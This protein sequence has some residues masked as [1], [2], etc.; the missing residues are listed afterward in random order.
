MRSCS[1]SQE[2]LNEISIVVRDS[3]KASS[4]GSAAS[5][6]A[7]FATRLM[8]MGMGS[9]SLVQSTPKITVAGFA[10]HGI[11]TAAYAGVE[12]CP[13]NQIL[14]IDNSYRRKSAGQYNESRGR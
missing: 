3:G 8:A 2:G 5:V 6:R 11:P 1:R 9:A 10:R 12:L 14:A 13:L 4:Q 7:F